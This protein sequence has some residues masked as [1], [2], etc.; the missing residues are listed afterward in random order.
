MEW[1][2]W[3]ILGVVLFLSE[4]FV[5]TDF[6]LAI[7]GFSAMALAAVAGSGLVASPSIQWALFGAIA[8][9][10]TVGFRKYFRDRFGSGEVKTRETELVGEIATALADIAAGGRGK[11]ELRGTVWA[12]RNASERTLAAGETAEVTQV[13]GLTL[14]VFKVD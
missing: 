13:D 5:P 11:V 2:A 8:I 10:A 9:G 6:F 1:W 7:L 4:L 12:A 14:H 3:V